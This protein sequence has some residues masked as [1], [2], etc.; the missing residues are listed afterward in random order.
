MACVNKNCKDPIC[1]GNLM[2]LH[3]PVK[4]QLLEKKKCDE[5]LMC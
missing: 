5:I 1:T 3:A 4:L 2:S